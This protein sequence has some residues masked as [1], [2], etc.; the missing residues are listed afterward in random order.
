MRLNNYSF[1]A[2]VRQTVCDYGNPIVKVN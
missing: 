2:I 1:I